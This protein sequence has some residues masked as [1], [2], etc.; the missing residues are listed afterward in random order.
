M[1]LLT[2]RQRQ[3]FNFIL[4]NIGSYGF[5]PTVSEI[6]NHFSFKSPNAVQDH[7]L[8]LEK[9]GYIS[10]YP[11]KS[12]GIEI[13]VSNFDNKEKKDSNI[14]EVPIVGQV[15]AGV[16]IMAYENIEGKIAVDRGLIKELS[17]SFALK[18]KGDSMI[19]AGILNGD[20][21][22]VHQQPVAEQGEI[23]VALIEDE[24]TVK[25]YFK[26]KNKIRLVPENDTMLPIIVDPKTKTIQI[27]GKV[28]VV[29]RR[30]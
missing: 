5:P 26:D 14:T 22:I 29:I 4:S 10:R 1:K 30:V 18:V 12:R 17:N 28:Q 2:N 13:L 27:L 11:H 9:K 19:N 24:T 8:A 16:P 6:Q 15:R 21:I 7:I 20:F 3:I 23:I 25:R